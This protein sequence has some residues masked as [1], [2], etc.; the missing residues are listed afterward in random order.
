MKHRQYGQ[1]LRAGDPVV[2]PLAI[3]PGADQGLVTQNTQLL[4]QG[5]LRDA[6]FALERS[7][8]GLTLSK[9]TQQE[10]AVGIGK[11]L[12]QPAGRISGLP[13]GFEG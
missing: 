4:G 8:T 3:A 2:N 12:E 7:H 13:E 5:W 11:R 10:Q 1:C 9:T 6:K